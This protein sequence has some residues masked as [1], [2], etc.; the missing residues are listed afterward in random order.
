MERASRRP[1][2]EIRTAT[3]DRGGGIAP[4][5]AEPG[6]GKADDDG[7]RAEH[8]GGKMQRVGGQRLALGVA[9][10]AMQRPRAPEIH[11]DIDHQHDERDRRQRRR[12]R[13]FAQ[14]APGLDQDA[15]GQHIEQGDDA[16]RGEALELAVAV[17]MLVV[18][19][20]V[21]N[22]HHQP[23]DDGRDQVDRGVQRFGDQRQ[24][25]DGDA[26]REFGRGHRGAG[27]D[28]D[29]RDAGFDWL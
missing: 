14:P 6:E 24:T 29:R 15:A 11:G 7:E 3:A 21:G 4:G 26:D 9:R 20:P 25:A 17:M 2:T 19:R 1:S 16:E 28:R 12:R 10:G 27:E 18:G 5:I 8:V 13:A 22:P 23:G